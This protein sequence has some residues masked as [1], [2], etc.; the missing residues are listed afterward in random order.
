MPAHSSVW[1]GTLAK[2]LEEFGSR[3]QRSVLF[4]RRTRWL[5]PESRNFSKA[6]ITER[7]QPADPTLPGRRP[8]LSPGGLRGVCRAAWMPLGAPGTP[9]R[10]QGSPGGTR[11][12]FGDSAAAD[13][14]TRQESSGFRLAAVQDFCSMVVFLSTLFPFK[15][16]VSPASTP[17][18]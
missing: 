6:A 1:V 5:C 9:S 17:A 7:E 10:L 13:H 18:S 3:H 16:K 11:G 8:G 12:V 2:V 4:G 15:C 14:P